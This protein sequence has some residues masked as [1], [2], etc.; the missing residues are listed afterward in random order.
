M[1]YATQ[2]NIRFHPDT[3]KEKATKAIHA[4]ERIHGVDATSK[5]RTRNKQRQ[6]EV[7]SGTNVA[8]GFLKST[9]LPKMKVPETVPPPAA[10]DIIQ[11]DFYYS[12]SELAKHYRGFGP[13]DTKIFAYPY[14]MALSVWEVKKYLKHHVKNWKC[15]RLIHGDEGNI[16]FI[17][18][19]QYDTGTTLYYIPVIPLYKMLKSRQTRKPATLL[20]S[21][22]SYLY[23]VACIPYYRQE[24]TYMYWE[25]EMILDWIEQDDESEFSNHK[26]ALEMAQWCGE[27]ME[28]KICNPENLE[29]FAARINTFRPENEFEREC[30][31]LAKSIFS[32]Y[33]DYPATSVFE[34]AEHVSGDADQEDEIITM[35]KYISFIADNK[36][37]LYETL[38][39]C[40]NN[41]FNEYTKIEEPVIVKTFDGS[42]SNKSNLDFE[43]RLFPLI[44]ELCYLLDTH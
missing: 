35:E 38:A 14:N 16:F 31:E 8:N 1:K 28:G 6:K 18:R 20:L 43:N 21:V 11:T 30:W 34:H 7:C 24:D 5:G 26:R 29:V 9:F 33:T 36:G 10:A 23:H 37:W 39:E 12:L 3:K 2:Y 25:Y 13:T 19:E 41:E 40:V 15:I 27:K 44:G 32:V 4:V 17:S 42:T 22:F